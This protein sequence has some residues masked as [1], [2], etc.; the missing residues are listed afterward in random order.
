MTRDFILV[1]L[2][3]IKMGKLIDAWSDVKVGRCYK[4]HEIPRTDVLIYMCVTCE[5]WYCDRCR[6]RV[7]TYPDGPSRHVCKTCYWEAKGE[8]WIGK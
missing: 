7:H 4:H 1:V 5:K 3:G 6:Y 8:S 2:I